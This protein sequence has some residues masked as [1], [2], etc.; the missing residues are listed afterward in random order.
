LIGEA[1]GL[2]ISS[3]L[4]Q[5][6]EKD[7]SEKIHQETKSDKKLLPTSLLTVNH[8]ITHSLRSKDISIKAT[9]PTA[10]ST[11]HIQ[12]ALS[13]NICISYIYRLFIEM[14]QSNLQNSKTN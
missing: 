6:V 9:R 12:D 10:C 14:E 11:L 8:T 1:F 5:R 7:M 4:K 2:H 13:V 3:T